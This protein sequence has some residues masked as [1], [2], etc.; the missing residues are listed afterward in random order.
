MIS[1]LLSAHNE[2]SNPFFWKTLDMLKMLQNGGARVEVLVGVAPGSDDTL[3]R[4]EQRNV[5]FISVKQPNR[6]ARFNAAFDQ[7]SCGPSDWVVLNHPRS[8]LGPDAFTALDLLPSRYQWGAFTHQFD[9]DHPLLSFT[10]WWSNHVRGDIKQIFY[11]DHCLFV[12]RKVFEK[13]GGIPEVDIFED[14]LFSQK[15]SQVCVPTRL[16][17][18]STTSAIR[19][20]SNGIWKQAILNQLLKVQFVMGAD[21]AKMN[22]S[23][24]RGV[25]LNCT[26]EEGWQ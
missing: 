2:S 1:V 22:K 19:F 18:K 8:V 26:S 7:I 10:S 4:L 23:Y 15:L 21:H 17:W 6:A 11:L 20:T 12:R 25:N 5:K 13:V 3:R 24:E 16:P 9:I 14:T